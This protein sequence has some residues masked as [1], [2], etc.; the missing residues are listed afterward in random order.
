[1]I[2][3][4]VFLLVKPRPVPCRL[5]QNPA[6]DFDV[7]VGG[8]ITRLG[9][10]QDVQILLDYAA[11]ILKG[12]ELGIASVSASDVFAGTGIADPTNPNVGNWMCVHSSPAPEKLARLGASRVS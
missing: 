2:T 5:P 9:T 6:Y 10:K 8:H 1:M 4:P 12:A 11:D 7:L 3:F